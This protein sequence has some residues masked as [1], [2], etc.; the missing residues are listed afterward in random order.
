MID[1]LFKVLSPPRPRQAV[2]IFLEGSDPD[3]LLIQRH[4]PVAIS[5]SLRLRYLSVQ[6]G[7]YWA[8]IV[9]HYLKNFGFEPTRNGLLAT[10]L[11]V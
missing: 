6:A 3:V 5:E 1:D 2:A 11:C 10:S 8:S 4:W 7:V 9:A